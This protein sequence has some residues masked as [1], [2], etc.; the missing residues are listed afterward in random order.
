MLGSAQSGRQRELL[1]SSIFS[2][3]PR[4][5]CDLWTLWMSLLDF[6]IFLRWWPVRKDNQFLLLW[7]HGQG[8]LKASQ[9][10]SLLI[11]ILLSSSLKSLCRDFQAAK[12][13]WPLH[14]PKGWYQAAHKGGWRPYSYQLGHVCTLAHLKLCLQGSLKRCKAPNL[15]SQ[16][17]EGFQKGKKG[18]R[19]ICAFQKFGISFGRCFLSTRTKIFK[20]HLLREKCLKIWVCEQVYPWSGQLSYRQATESSF[21]NLKSNSW[22]VLQLLLQ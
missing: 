12:G 22:K 16:N 3:E 13:R 2:Q 11:L 5:S 4:R 8:I 10:F 20:M 14:C 19:Q 6:R 7:R 17:F 18:P 15:N 21:S 1:Y 9:W